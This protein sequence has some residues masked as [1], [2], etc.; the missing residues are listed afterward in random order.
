MPRLR[1]ALRTLAK[2]P[3]LSAVVILSLGLGIGV[4]TAIF[5]LLHQVV[6]ASLPIPHPEQLVLITS[7]GDLKNGR[8][9]TNDSGDM[10]YIFNWRTLRELEKHT[11]LA[12]VAGF[13]TFAGNIP[14]CR[15]TIAG[16]MLQIGRASCRERV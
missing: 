1:F 3:L 4:N 14:F 2:S 8:T 9:S 15:Q 6:L 11:E 16:T 7:P 13:D 10:P 12:T 5:S